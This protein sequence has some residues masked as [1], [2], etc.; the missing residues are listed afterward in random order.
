VL[1]DGAT[2]APGGD[3]EAEVV[4]DIVQA[5][6]M[7]PGL[8]QV[9]VYIGGSNGLDDANLLN[10]MGSENICKQISSSW[11]WMPDDPSTDDVFFE[12]FAAQGQSFLDASGDAGAYDAGINPFFYPA[13]DVYV[14]AVGGTSLTTAG[15]GGPWTSEIA[16]TNS[17][18][19]ISPDGITIP[20]WQS[21][22]A[23]SSNGGSAT[24]RNIPDVAMEATST[25][26]S[27]TLARA[28][29]AGR[30]PALRLRGGLVSRR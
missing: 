4:L 10:S 26:M 30:A 17:G 9:R 24:L 21:G 5:I 12:E 23:S 29:A 6:G 18:G 13:E 25:T 22:V 16:W 19:G 7:A 20:G 27:A 28:V 15:A 1:L 3:G 2:G 14:T 11:S 8:S